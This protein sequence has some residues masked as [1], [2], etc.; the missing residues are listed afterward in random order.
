MFSEPIRRPSAR[1]NVLADGI[2]PRPRAPRP[3]VS[4]TCRAAG[5]IAS[6]VPDSGRALARS[7]TATCHPC[8]WRCTAVASRPMPPPMMTAPDL[9]PLSHRAGNPL[10]ELTQR[11]GSQRFT[12]VRYPRNHRRGPRRPGGPQ[13]Q[14]PGN[15]GRDALAGPLATE[16]EA[17][18]SGACTSPPG[19]VPAPGRRGCLTG[20]GT[21]MHPEPPGSARCSPRRPAGPSPGE[22]W[23]PMSKGCAEIAQVARHLVWWRMRSM[24]QTW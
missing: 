14:G 24:S 2:A 18:P 4:R 15:A 12:D 6:A 1:R 5:Q 23:E 8:A 19:S 3:R 20:P 17:I 10:H 22:V 21:A 11:D 16:P 9:L 13:R 7:C